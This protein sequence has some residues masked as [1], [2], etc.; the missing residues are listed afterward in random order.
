MKKTIYTVIPIDRLCSIMEYGLVT[1]DK[2]N[3]LN[4]ED[5]LKKVNFDE[6]EIGYIYGSTCIRNAIDWFKVIKKQLDIPCLLLKY[7]IDNSVIEQDICSPHQIKTDIRFKGISIPPEDITVVGVTVYKNYYTDFSNKK[8]IP[9]LKMSDIESYLINDMPLMMGIHKKTMNELKKDEKGIYYTVTIQE[10]V[11]LLKTIPQF[12]YSLIAALST[13]E[14]FEVA[15]RPATFTTDIENAIAWKN[16]VEH[17]SG[18]KAR[19][20]KCSI[21]NS[22]MANNYTVINSRFSN[23]KALMPINTKSVIKVI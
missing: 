18:N 14:E 9:L 1:N 5:D 13:V 20:L 15:G 11:K 21:Q 7:D 8:E 6:T 22:I 3:Q 12:D 23:V 4:I 2:L 10:G 17:L 19:I 16:I